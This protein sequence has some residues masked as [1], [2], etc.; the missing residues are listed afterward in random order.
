MFGLLAHYLNSQ[1]SR[2]VVV[3]V[4]NEVLAAVQQAKY[5]P[6]ASKVS[7]DL[8]KEQVKEI[9]YCTYRDFKSGRVP[10]DA[11][12]LVDEVDSLFFGDRPVVEKKMKK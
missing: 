2:K 10:T 3:V 12:L 6:W 4:P 1:L 5:C 8:Y 9:F 11:L 7:S